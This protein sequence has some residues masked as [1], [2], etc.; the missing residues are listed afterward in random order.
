[1]LNEVLWGKCEGCVRKLMEPVGC[2]S[3]P[4][5]HA[6][7]LSHDVIALFASVKSGSCPTIS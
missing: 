6:L 7:I 4:R 3:I 5:F 2:V 1:M